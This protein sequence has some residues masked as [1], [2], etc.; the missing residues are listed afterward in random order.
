MLARET[1]EA[2]ASFVGDDANLLIASRQVVARQPTAGSLVWLVAQ[3]LAAPNPRKALWDAVD[4]LEADNTARVLGRELPSDCCVCVIG[5][6]DA[7]SSAL[8]NRRDLRILAIETDAY[9][10]RRIERLVD[11]EY[12][13]TCV[14]LE[15]LG[16][17]VAE[18]THV[19]FDV[20]AVGPE[21]LLAGQPALAAAAVAGHWG[22]PTWG[23]GGVGVVLPQRM[24][25]GLTRRWHESDTS[26]LWYRIH[27]E[28]PVE[29]LT[30]LVMPD[31]LHAQDGRPFQTTCPV[32][33]ELF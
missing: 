4:E 19:L 16:Q 33:P 25:D 14:P 12:E 13:A 8:R 9:S 2:L 26:P 22:V 24:Y 20:N 30:A 11:N 29:V 21:S 18:A 23:V 27:E 6:P 1:A 10:E 31:G 17:A 7:L 15:G 3:V 28:L 32:V 5:W